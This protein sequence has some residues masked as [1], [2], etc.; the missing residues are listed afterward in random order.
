MA[1]FKRARAKAKSTPHSDLRPEN[2]VGAEGKTEK[3]WVQTQLRMELEA[4]L[5]VARDLP[6]RQNLARLVNLRNRLQTVLIQV[7]REALADMASREK[8]GRS[9]RRMERWN[10]LLPTAGL[11]KQNKKMIAD[12]QAHIEEL[13]KEGRA[14][15]ARWQVACTWGTWC[16]YVLKRPITELSKSLQGKVGK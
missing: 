9:L 6:K 14:P 8:P 16:W 11:R 13:V 2:V 1:N 10:D 12:Q 15:A 7:D 3:E 4:K 5:Q